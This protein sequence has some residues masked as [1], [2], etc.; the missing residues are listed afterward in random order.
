MNVLMLAPEPFFQPRGTPISIHFRI[1]ALADLGHRTDLITYPLGEDLAFPNFTIFRVPNLLRLRRIKIGP[2]AAK[3]PLDGLMVVKTLSALLR[4]RYDVIFSHEEAGWFGAFFGRLFRIPHIY[5][6]HSSLPQQLENFNF[7][8]SRALKGIF[9]DLERYV[10]RNSKAV[11][12]ICRDLLDYVKDQ[13]FADKAV[14]LENFMDFADFAA[15]P[16][17]P[18]EV[19]GIRATVAPGGEKIVLYAGNFEPY[20][21]IP[22]LIEAFAQVRSRAVLLIVGGVKAEHDAARQM[23]E[24][25]GAG[26]R[27]AFVEKVAPRKVPLYVA[28]SDVLVSPR[29]SGTNTPLKIYSFLKAGKPFVATR[30]WTHTQVLDDSV[31]VLADPNPESFAAG[32]TDA[33]ETEE[34]QTRAREAKRRADRDYIYPRYLEK[35]TE[36]LNKATGR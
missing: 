3:L 34:A 8:R 20:Q 27:I 4:R 36:A 17:S 18:E 12:V 5:D 10:L 1:K 35:I 33:L 28:A 25:L 7:S 6:M 22:L 21:G 24:K 26:G 13:G 31:A 32:L 15:A 19:A 14:F 23:A 2:S 30:L 16:P 11:I 29:V 9:D